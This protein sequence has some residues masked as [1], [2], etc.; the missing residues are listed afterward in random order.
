MQIKLPIQLTGIDHADFENPDRDLIGKQFAEGKATITVINLS[1][2]TPGHVSV[3]RNIDGKVWSV[4]AWMI[5]R[6]VGEPGATAAR[7][8]RNSDRVQTI[9]HRKKNSLKSRM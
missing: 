8:S 3:L 9:L 4:P 7:Y 5:R 2:T 6:I 1:R